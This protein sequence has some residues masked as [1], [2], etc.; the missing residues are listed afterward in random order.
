MPLA[1]SQVAVDPLKLQQI[2]YCMVACVKH[3]SSH[4]VAKHLRAGAGAKY[5]ARNRCKK[6]VKR[7]PQ[8]KLTLALT[9]CGIR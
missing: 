8:V 4:D 2:V 6:N 9:R 3:D 5:Q 7:Q 1:E